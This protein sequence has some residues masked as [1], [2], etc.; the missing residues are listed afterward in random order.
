[1]GLFS[2][3]KKPKCPIHGISYSIDKDYMCQMY[4][5]CPKCRAKAREEK[6]TH[7]KIKEL[8]AKIKKLEEDAAKTA[9]TTLGEESG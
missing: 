4:Y 9:A 2:L 5:F 8:E 1:M 6:A 7:L 3:F